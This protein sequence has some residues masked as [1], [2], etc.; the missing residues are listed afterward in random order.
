MCYHLLPHSL[1]SLS[2]PN[3]PIPPTVDRGVSDTTMRGRETRVREG[4]GGAAWVMLGG[5]NKM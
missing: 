1:A 5:S 2:A 3:A 4:G